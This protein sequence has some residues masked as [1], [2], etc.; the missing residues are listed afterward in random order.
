MGLLT[1]DSLPQ[2]PASAGAGLKCRQEFSKDRHVSDK[3][4]ALE[5]APVALPQEAELGVELAQTL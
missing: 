5:S 3:L 4:Q 1:A 2:R